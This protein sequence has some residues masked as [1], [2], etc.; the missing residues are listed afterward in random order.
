MD[1]P[2]RVVD[3]V[4]SRV[5][6]LQSLSS[7]EPPVR[8]PWRSELSTPQFGPICEDLLAVSLTAAAGGLATIGRPM[9]DRGVDL[10]LRRL[11][12]LLT[13]PIQVK[14]F[15]HVSPDAT[16]SEDLLVSDIHDAPGGYLAFVHAPLPYDQLYRRLFLIPIAEFRERCPVGTV[17]G[18]QAFQFVA[19][20]DPEG[21]DLWTEFLMDIDRL[22]EWL[23]AIPGW[24]HPVPFPPSSTNDTL[25]ELT[26][27][28]SHDNL[29]E[30]HLG[31][32]WATSEIERAALDRMVIVEDRVRLDTVTLL[33][34]DLGSQQIGGL[35]I[36]TA[37]Y[38]PDRRIHFDVKRRGFFIDPK[39]YVLLLLLDQ[40][41]RPG[42]FCLLIPSEAIPELGYSETLT[43]D[44]LTRRFR[45]YQLPVEQFGP[46]LLSRVFGE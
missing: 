41:R 20:V 42:E 33:L 23:A 24:T 8:P 21:K 16:V 31:R 2:D 27:K 28:S 38:P 12:S 14:G 37:T 40:L 6:P 19:N 10:Y 29:S 18:K 11:R 34:H 25:L 7:L 13:V 46:A 9:V 30:A 43:L 45:P 15:T 4:E 17:A 44:P 35:H 26:E 32:L 22:P 39:L 5:I 3:V 1:L 36:R